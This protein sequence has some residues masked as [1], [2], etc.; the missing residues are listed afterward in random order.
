[1]LCV[2]Q[3]FSQHNGQNWQYNSLLSRPFSN[4]GTNESY[5]SYLFYF[6]RFQCNGLVKYW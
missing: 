3:L 1:M 2:I 6:G 5:P 4:H